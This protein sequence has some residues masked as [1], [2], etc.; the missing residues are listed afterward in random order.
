[1]GQAI[2]IAEQTPKLQSTNYSSTPK[3]FTPESNESTPRFSL[4]SRSCSSNSISNLS[5]LTC[6]STTS[7]QSTTSISGRFVSYDE[8]Q[9]AIIYIQPNNNNQQSQSWTIKLSPK[10]QQPYIYNNNNNNNKQQ[11]QQQHD[12]SKDGNEDEQYVI[13]GICDATLLDSGYKHKYYGYG[14]SVT[15]CHGIKFYSYSTSFCID[16]QI[17]INYDCKKRQISFWCDGKQKERI[18]NIQNNAFNETAI[19][20]KSYNDNYQIQLLS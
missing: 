1:M 18:I 12:E 19:I 2:S 7:Q 6:T 10:Y 15:Y 16:S 3:Y 17:V 9:N 20:I 14:Y 13:F 11:Q 4:K 8:D 5:Q